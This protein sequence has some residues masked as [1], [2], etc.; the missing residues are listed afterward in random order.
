[1]FGDPV[2]R[3]PIGRGFVGR[4]S[5]GAAQRVSPGGGQ[6]LVRPLPLAKAGR[7]AK[8]TGLPNAPTQAAASAVW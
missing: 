3:E 1:M 2:G 6:T 5:A 4:R 7:R 8:T